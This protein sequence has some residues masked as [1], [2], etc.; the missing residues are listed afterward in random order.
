MFEGRSTFLS[1]TEER[2]IRSGKCEWDCAVTSSIENARST[3]QGSRRAI[4]CAYRTRRSR[5]S[6]VPAFLRPVFGYHSCWRT[7]SECSGPMTKSDD[8]R[9]SGKQRGGDRAVRLEVALKSNLKKRKEQARARV[10]ADV[11]GAATPDQGRQLK[12]GGDDNKG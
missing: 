11:S 12:P 3:I 10:R 5:A 1:E 2:R 7:G 6:K 8:A 4:A 9:S